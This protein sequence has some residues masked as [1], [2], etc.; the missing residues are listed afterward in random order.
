[1]SSHLHPRAEA[2]PRLSTIEAKSPSPPSPTCSHW[3]KLSFSTLLERFKEPEF[4]KSLMESRVGCV[5]C[6]RALEPSKLWACLHCK[7]KV[8]EATRCGRSGQKHSIKHNDENKEHSLVINLGTRVVWCYICDFEVDRIELKNESLKDKIVLPQQLKECLTP[9]EKAGGDE[10]T[11]G[12][13]NTSITSK[14]Y[15]EY[16]SNPKGGIVGLANLGN[17]C[18]LNS[19]LQALLHCAPMVAFFVDLEL[20]HDLPRMS[21]LDGPRLKLAEEFSLLTKKYWSGQF[22]VCAPR[23][24]VHSVW[25]LNPFFHGYG[26]HDSQE[27]IRCLLDNLHEGL[28]EFYNYPFPEITEQKKERRIT[29]KINQ[30]KR[31]LRQR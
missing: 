11:T 1:M 21:R 29:K 31:T 13:T 14:K 15:K 20:K 6:A 25:Q 10:P 8:E 24:I 7:G 18:F 27:F 9:E 5:D 23:E 26:Q 2:E 22:S 19:A 12:G 17:T 30:T 4:Q 3:Q 28:K 16:Y